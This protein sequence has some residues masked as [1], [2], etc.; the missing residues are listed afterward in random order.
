MLRDSHDD[1]RQVLE[2]VFIDNRHVAAGIP[3][4][5]IGHDYRDQLRNDGKFRKYL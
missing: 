3:I 4:K 5:L 2:C 1:Y